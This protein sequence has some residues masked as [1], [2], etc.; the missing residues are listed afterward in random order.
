MKIRHIA[1]RAM[2]LAIAGALLAA[3]TAGADYDPARLRAESFLKLNPIQYEPISYGERVQT[4][5]ERAKLTRLPL[6][7]VELPFTGGVVTPS[8]IPLRYERTLDFTPREMTFRLKAKPKPN[9]FVAV[10][11]EF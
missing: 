6:P 5:S 10:E 1:S 9:R 11:L 2:P 8:Q 4:Q 7:A 3:G